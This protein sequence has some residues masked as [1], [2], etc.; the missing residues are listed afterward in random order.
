MAFEIKRTSHV[1]NDGVKIALT[2]ESGSGKT[3][4]TSTLSRPFVLSSEHGLLSLH[5]FDI[6]YVEIASINDLKEVKENLVREEI[7]NSFD[8]LVVDSI[9]DIAERCLL[10]YKK[11]TKDTRQAYSNMMDKVMDELLSICSIIGKDLVCI[12]KYGRI[13]DPLTGKV[14]YGPDVPSDKFATKMPYLFDEVLIM[15]TGFDAENNY[16]RRIQTF[17]D[18]SIAGKDRS[19][20]LEPYEPADLGAIISKIKGGIAHGEE[21]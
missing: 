2:G 16:I 6:P 7:W 14:S 10:E 17:N 18:G 3:W 19:G 12:Y 11:T 8:T 1:T 5:K 4:Q 21:N 15:R 20:C 9:S 13:Q